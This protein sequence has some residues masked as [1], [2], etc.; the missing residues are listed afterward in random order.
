MAAILPPLST[1]EITNTQPTAQ[2]QVIDKG[3]LIH[4]IR[5]SIGPDADPRSAIAQA[6]T[7]LAHQLLQAS[8]NPTAVRQIASDLQQNAE[9]IATF[10]TGA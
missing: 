4:Q 9:E 5:E 1:P 3:L 7:I 2:E 8:G 10:C 6:I